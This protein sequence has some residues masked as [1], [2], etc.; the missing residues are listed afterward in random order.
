MQTC[1]HV[2]A[3]LYVYTCTMYMYMYM[4]IPYSRKFGSHMVRYRHIHMCI[5]GGLSRFLINACPLAINL[6]VHPYNPD[7][8][9]ESAKSVLDIHVWLVIITFRENFDQPPLVIH[10]QCRYIFVHVYVYTHNTYRLFWL[11][12]NL[13][14]YTCLSRPPN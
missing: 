7:Q 3:V 10:V 9:A 12:F 2:H 1:V 6:R 8:S 11:I 13:A 4:Y 14:V 5:S